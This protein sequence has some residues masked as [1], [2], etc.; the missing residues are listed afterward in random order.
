[1]PFMG[2]TSTTTTMAS[3][4]MLVEPG[5]APAAGEADGE[6]APAP[7]Q[8]TGA[9]TTTA[10]TTT[11]V[12]TTTWVIPLGTRCAAAAL[13]S[14]AGHAFSYGWDASCIS[15]SDQCDGCNEC[16]AT[17]T[18]DCP[19]H[20]L[21][22]KGKCYRVNQKTTDFYGAQQWCKDEGQKAKRNAS[23][24]VIHEK[25]ENEFVWR[26]CHAEADPITYPRNS[27]RR[28]CWLG[29]WEKAATGDETTPQ[30]QQI[31]EW[32]DGSSVKGNKYENWGLRPGMGDLKDDGNKYYEPNNER[33]KRTPAGMDVRHAIMNQ[34]EGGML[35]YWYDKPAAFQAHAAC[36]MNA[37]QNAEK[38]D[39]GKLPAAPAVAFWQLRR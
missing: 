32:A 11:T 35:G 28:S 39:V 22:Y 26:I 27:T 8:A 5:P 30:E 21:S 13:F 2:M 37:V 29:M 38:P 23:L 18:V 24:V 15:H 12:T 36:E 20:W 19:N 34:K 9:I 4:P 6:P 16:V 1:M 33:S 10:G 3:E 7:A 17:G 14:C 31:W 25:Q